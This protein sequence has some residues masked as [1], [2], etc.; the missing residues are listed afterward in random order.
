MHSNHSIS[1]LW[2]LKLDKTKGCIHIGNRI[3]KA[4]DL[5]DYS[6]KKGFVALGI[7]IDN[8]LQTIEDDENT[9]QLFFN[10]WEDMNTILHGST[11]W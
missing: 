3:I 9:K 4:S 10:N 11:N 1:E 6:D 2:P 8:A 5:S 7:I